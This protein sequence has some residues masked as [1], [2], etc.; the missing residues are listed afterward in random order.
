LTLEKSLVSWSSLL[1]SGISQGQLANV[2]PGALEI[3]DLPDLAALLAPR[4]LTIREAVDALGRPI[5]RE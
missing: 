1:E 4:K 3:Y 2:V 5:L